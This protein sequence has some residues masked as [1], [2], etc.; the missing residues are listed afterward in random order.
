MLTIG[1]CVV[2]GRNANPASVLASTGSKYIYPGLCR[3]I[4]DRIAIYIIGCN[5][6]NDY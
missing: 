3:V 4:V 5:G 1:E 6:G 2:K